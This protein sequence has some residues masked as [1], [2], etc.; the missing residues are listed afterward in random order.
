[1]GEYSGQREIAGVG[2]SWRYAGA[3]QGWVK[4]EWRGATIVQ[5]P[6]PLPE[7]SNPLHFWQEG[8]GGTG[9]AVNGEMHFAEATETLVVT[10]LETVE[11]R[12]RNEL[13]FSAEYPQP[14]QPHIPEPGEPVR[15]G[16]VEPPPESDLF[17]YLYLAQWPEISA[18]ELRDRFVQ[19]DGQLAP[20][21][22]LYR[23]ML[24][25]AEEG[26]RA[27]VVQVDLFL[28]GRE[29]YR[30]RYLGDISG[31]GEPLA[32]LPA[33]NRELRQSPP[34]DLE[35]FQRRAEVALQ[36]SWADLCRYWQG[37]A[38][39][40]REQQ[41]WQNLIALAGQPG[42]NPGLG[43]QLSRVLA[44]AALISRIVA[45]E[46]DSGGGNAEE[47]Y[48][49]APRLLDGI[50]ATV[51]L[52]GDIFPLPPAGSPETAPTESAIVPYA[53]GDV[54]LVRQRLQGYRLGEVSRIESVMRGE[55]KESSETS[56][57]ES[58]TEERLSDSSTQGSDTELSG[59][60]GNL[61]LEAQNT[62]KD[63]FHYHYESQYAPP[64]N[65]L[66]VIVDETIQPENDEPQRTLDNR[67]TRAARRLTQRAASS[68]ERRLQW[69]RSSAT[70]HRD[71]RQTLRRI[72]AAGLDTNLRAV[73]RWVNKVYRCRTEDL[74]RHLVL[75]FTV[76]N[77]ASGT[78]AGAFSL[79]GLSLS[80]PPPLADAGVHTFQDIS[81]D[82]DS[83]AYYATLAVQYGVVELE[84]PPAPHAHSSVTF[85]GGEPLRGQS[86]AVAPGYSAHSAHVAV[87]PAPGASGLE[88]E[89]AVGQC[90]WR[91]SGPGSDTE[92][93]ELGGER[94]SVPVAVLSAGG[95]KGAGIDGS[96]SVVVEVAAT[97]TS[98]A[99]ER[100]KLATYKAI[101]A[102]CERQRERY[103]ATVSSWS[104]ASRVSPD[105][106]R[107]TVRTALRRDIVRQLLQRARHQ[108]GEGG[109]VAAGRQ[110]YVQFFDRALAW[111]DMAYAF[112]VK[113]EDDLGTAIEQHYSGGDQL[114]SAFLQAGSAR[115]L[116]PVTPEFSYRLLYFLASGQIWPGTDPLTPTFC[117]QLKGGADRRYV[118][119][120]NALKESAEIPTPELPQED[121]ELVVPTEMT[122]LQD[123]E[124]LPVF[125]GG[126]S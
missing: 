109:D 72:D 41:C 71:E 32:G 50:R 5:V 105:K 43:D 61:L 13:L 6:L 108:T 54:K 10:R 36:M 80:E 9:L 76:R 30:G 83:D 78:I 87:T 37:E 121:W 67:A 93:L 47:V 94:E 88:L 8:P 116:M 1:M 28:S 11:G 34:V 26:R 111:E 15:S 27:M 102:G 74:G 3:A 58:R 123:G 118:E 107:Q 84:P 31:L 122:V 96:Y 62:Q 90:A 112:T 35:D 4:V 12:A 14:P 114:L 104:G 17:P 46:S 89:V 44:T 56:L 117:P 21:G 73:Y 115:V 19:Y 38:Y 99:L 124:Q 98:E 55:L 65:Q 92:T 18:A 33:L 66:Q 126:E 52:P 53:I 97:L 70:V 23:A 75:E 82:P 2:F 120:V 25:A 69:Q 64:A 24:E 45:T 125:E 22:S 85:L 79:R 57:H 77:P 29:P 59:W 68:L 40:K 86:V 39:G 91:Y 100:W 106:V 7:D 16:V 60:R 113:T 103:Y 81:T 95:G 48:W 49:S 119:L 20:E 42:F 110:R 63:N 101:S 51:I